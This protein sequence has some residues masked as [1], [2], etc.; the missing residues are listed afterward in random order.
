MPNTTVERVLIAPSGMTLSKNAYAK[1]Y[2]LIY[3]IAATDIDISYDVVVDRV[4]DEMLLSNV[5]VHSVKSNVPPRVKYHYAVF[6]QAWQ[7][8]AETPVDIYHHM[9]LSPP[10]FNPLLLNDLDVGTVIGPI[11]APHSVPISSMRNVIQRY[12]GVSV[13]D[14]ITRGLHKTLPV[15]R[16]LIDTVRKAGFRRTLRTAD[17]IVVV[18]E[19]VAKYCASFIEDD[20]KISVIPYGVDMEFFSF[21]ERDP[22]NTDIAA[23]GLLKERKG[24]DDLLEAF[25]AV[26]EAHPNAHLH[27]FGDGPQQEELEALARTEGIAD[28]TTF[29]GYVSH[30]TIRDFLSECRLFVHPSHSEGFSHVRLEALA[31]GCPTIGTDIMGA[32][33]MVVD[34]E[35]GISVQPGDRKE[36]AEAMITLLSN[37]ELLR[38]MS[39]NCRDHIK[40]NYNFDKIGEEWIEVYQSLS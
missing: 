21:S 34:G 24:F 10:W 19:A 23:I 28:K 18:N 32:D 2:N 4:E 1:I 20:E 29:H 9:D 36:L 40:E 33:G 39:F 26:V 16:L 8:L 35:T 30:T 37:D 14:P 27:I 6:R 5:T 22:D 17:R 31:S 11:Q 15:I 7:R 3:S 25:P 38:E 13:P 12:T